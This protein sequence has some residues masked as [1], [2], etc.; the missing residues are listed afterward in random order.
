MWLAL[1]L[2]LWGLPVVVIGLWTGPTVAWFALLA[3]GLGNALLDVFGFSLLNR[4]FPDHLA[5][6]AWGALHAG[7]AAAAVA[8]GSLAAPLLVV[9]SA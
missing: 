1:G 5:G 4:L 6:R 3:L 9:L 2:C 7:A 8:L